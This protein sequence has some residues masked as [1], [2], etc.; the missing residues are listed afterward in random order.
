MPDCESCWEDDTSD[1]ED[2]LLQTVDKEEIL[3][4]GTRE[5]K[6]RRKRS[7][8]AK[9]KVGNDKLI[10]FQFD[11]GATCNVFKTGLTCRKANDACV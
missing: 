10:E 8:V 4:A 7:I 3:V 5:Q 9:I 1:G 6:E 2:E 11:T